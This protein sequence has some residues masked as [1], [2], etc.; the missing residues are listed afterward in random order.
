VVSAIS[1]PS[2]PEPAKARDSYYTRQEVYEASLAYFHGDQLAADVFTDKYALQDQEGRFVELTPQDMHRRLAREFARIEA[3]YPNGLSEDEIFSLMDSFRYV[4][5][6]GS[7]MHAIGNNYTYESASNC[8]VLPTPTDSYSGILFTDQ[9]QAQIMKR[10][11]GVGFDISSI[12]PKGMKT[13]NA[14]RTTDGI[15]IFMERFSNTCREVAQG[16]RRGALMLSIHIKHPEILTFVDIKRDRKKVTGANLSIR[17]TDDFMRAVQDDQDFQLQW[18][19]DVPDPKIVRTVRAREIWDKIIDAAWDS[20]EPGLLFWDTIRRE[21]PSDCYEEEG[22]KS[23]S[24]NPCQPAWALVLTPKGLKS[25]GQLQIGDVIW[26][27]KKWTRVLN[28]WSTGL[29]PV[30]GYRTAAGV[31]YGTEEHRVV[32]ARE[33]VEVRYAT[34]IDNAYSPK[35]KIDAEKEVDPA[36]LRDGLLVGAG[37]FDTRALCDAL[38]VGANDL[39]DLFKDRTV[40][41][42]VDEKLRGNEFFWRLRPCDLSA[43]V[44]KAVRTVPE[45]RPVPSEYMVG[46]EEQTRGFLRGLF[47]TLGRV[48]ESPKRSRVFLRST[49]SELIFSVQHLLSTLGINSVYSLQQTRLFTDEQGNVYESVDGHELSIGEDCARFRDLIGFIQKDRQAAVDRIASL[50]W[51][52]ERFRDQETLPILSTEVCGVHEV[53]DLTVDCEEHTYWT[54]GV[55]VSNCAEIPLSPYDA[56]RLMVLNTIS[57]VERAF[58]PDAYFDFELFKEHAQKAQRL[59]DDL[60]DLELEK[61]D[62]IIAKV[63]SDAESEEIKAIELSLWHKVRAANERGRRTGL[64]VTALGDTLA[65]LNLRYGSPESIEMTEAIYGALGCAVEMQSCLLAKERGAFP[66]FRH[67]REQDNPY[68]NR[69]FHASPDV[70]ALWRLYG[71]RNIATTTTAPVGSV[72]TLTRT[73]SGIE[74]VYLLKHTRRRKVR[75]DNP[76]VRVDFVDEIGDKWQEYTVYHPG[77]EKWMEVTGKKDVEESPYWKA[78]SRDVDWMASVDIQAAAQRWISHSISK[79]ANLPK[80]A[81]RELVSNVYFRAWQAGCKGFTIYR[82]GSRSGVLLDASEAQKNKKGSRP[83]RLEEHEA[84]KRPPFLA[85]DI[86]FTHTRENDCNTEWVFIVGLLENRPYE[87][88]GGLSSSLLDIPRDLPKGLVVKNKKASSS[89]DLHVGKI[90]VKDIVATLDHPTHSAFTRVTSTALRH[91]VPVHYI[92]EQLLKERSSEFHTLAKSLARVLKDYIIDGVR[93]ASE[94]GCKLCGAAELV[95]QEGCVRCTSCGYSK[96]K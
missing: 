18:P 85:C 11:G 21:T 43:S 44:Q 53:F 88:F 20:A 48:Y 47:S 76:N 87:V 59:M 2:F 69:I 41:S 25:I 80:E 89:Y 55:L 94:K 28:K 6:Q 95:Y 46:S 67:D 79:T 65:A 16:G 4:V 64:G 75:G 30:F 31:F 90:V 7:P 19:I 50:N 34:S 49:S 40:R 57:Y 63:E 68:L 45:L 73:T 3:K 72:S 5:A 14:A 54:G 60:V 56:C 52:S 83:Q 1:F 86:K 27:G 17:I 9:E 8:Y 24:T 74:P 29:K 32:Q 39:E 82:E 61:L 70:Y 96:C 51:I 91:G 81:T 15:S 22:F 84:P 92:V 42:F 38:F 33:K 23:H 12:R 10:R 58:E 35:E 37:F 26:S 36:A 13:A 77:F 66:V 93:S 78:T 62:R 71:R